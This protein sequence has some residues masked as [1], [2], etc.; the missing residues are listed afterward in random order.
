MKLLP[1][2]QTRRNRD[3]RKAALVGMAAGLAGGWA[4]SGFSA[5]WEH[6]DGGTPVPGQL[7]HASRQEWDSTTNAA[8]AVA[9]RLHTTP[10]SAGQRVRG[11]V[12]VHY[13]IAAAMG[14]AYGVWREAFPRTR[15]GAGS[16]FGAALWLSAQEIGMPLM[17]L[18]GSPRQYSLR[19]QAQSLGE[20]V[21]YGITVEMAA[22]AWER[23][24]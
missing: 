18:S 22:R 23:A 5:L 16:A 21:A 4:M 11:A 20:H 15:L 8:Q 10:L 1:W 3:W 7:M 13:A 14:A 12:A 9:R 6:A 24:R 2:G 19:E 17:H